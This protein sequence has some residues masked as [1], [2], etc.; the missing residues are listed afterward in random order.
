VKIQE[1]VQALLGR[2]KSERRAAADAP[3]GYRNGYGKPRR[4]SMMS[5][6]I[7]VRRSR[8]REL[9]ARFESR[10]LPLFLRGTKEVGEL[11]PELYLALMS[12]SASALTSAARERGGNSGSRRSPGGWSPFFAPGSPTVPVKQ[13]SR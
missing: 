8:V 1:F 2:R 3:A 7:T 11:L 13:R 5:G 10:I 12:T 9:E 4:L 6:T